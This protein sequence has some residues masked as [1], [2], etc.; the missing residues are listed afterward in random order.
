MVRTRV[1][2]TLHI[3]R[4]KSSFWFYI[5]QIGNDTVPIQLAQCRFSG[6][7]ISNAK[8]IFQIKYTKAILPNSTSE[9]V[10]V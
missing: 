4:I 8:N 1:R 10:M 9:T 5:L 6:L 7:A 3:A 2:P